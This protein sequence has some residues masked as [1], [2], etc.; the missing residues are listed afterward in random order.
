MPASG[1]EL[2][3]VR[4]LLPRPACCRPGPLTA[5]YP[6][7][8]VTTAGAA[9][10]LVALSVGV[11]HHIPAPGRPGP[12]YAAG[13]AD[14]GTPL[15]G[16]ASVLAWISG[17]T[18]FH[19]SHQA[20]GL[21]PVYELLTGTR[22]LGNYWDGDWV[23]TGLRDALLAPGGVRTPAARAARRAFGTAGECDRI[24]TLISV[25][26]I[27]TLRDVRL[28]HPPE[29]IRP[30]F[31]PASARRAAAKPDEQ[32][33]VFVAGLPRPVLD[34]TARLVSRAL[35]DPEPDR[36]AA[37]SPADVVIDRLRVLQLAGTH[38]AGAA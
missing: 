18:E 16:A 2:A 38:R 14:L 15:P 13:T 3:A 30:E 32:L 21:Y 35:P 34:A 24:W 9:R 20:A 29:L 31:G 19:G 11:R 8:Q 23:L 27:A 10:E 12:P 7:R 37:R 5:R 28:A 36:R 4:Q 33:R 22:F 6:A 17:F 1:Q 25:G 26:A